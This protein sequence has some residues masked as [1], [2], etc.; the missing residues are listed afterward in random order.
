M[1]DYYIDTPY[2]SNMF[3]CRPVVA[4]DYINLL[5]TVESTN[6]VHTGTTTLEVLDISNVP[7]LLS[8]FLMNV[9]KRGNSRRSVEMLVPTG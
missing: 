3:M 7:S 4:V 6:K 2:L 1:E 9:T 8:T 5:F